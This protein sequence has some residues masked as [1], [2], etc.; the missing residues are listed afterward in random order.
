[1]KVI[2]MGAVALFALVASPSRAAETTIVVIFC[3]NPS[4]KA[5]D[6]IASDQPV[7]L[8]EDDELRYIVLTNSVQKSCFG[9]Y[10]GPIDQ[11]KGR[12]D[13]SGPGTPGGTREPN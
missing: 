5:G 3:S 4:L 7:V 12:P 2:L 10:R 8:N 13:G 9:P 6:R 1:V 11:C